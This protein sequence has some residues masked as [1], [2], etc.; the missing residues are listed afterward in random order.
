MSLASLIVD[1]VTEVLDIYLLKSLNLMHRP[2]RLV[3]WAQRLFNLSPHY[4]CSSRTRYYFISAPQAICVISYRWAMFVPGPKLETSPL[5]S[6][7]IKNY[8]DPLDTQVN[9]AYHATQKTRFTAWSGTMIV[10]DTGPKLPLQ[11]P[12]GLV[13]RCSGI[14]LEHSEI[15]SRGGRGYGIIE[16]KG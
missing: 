5:E 8:R 1:S 6:P 7:P 2:A 9:T 14:L 11:V 3:P 16:H 15:F 10:R 4:R 12:G 13:L